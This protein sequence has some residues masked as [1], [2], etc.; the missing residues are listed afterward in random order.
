[1]NEM[2]SAGPS[3]PQAFYPAPAVNE[4]D[5]HYPSSAP[6]VIPSCPFPF[7]SDGV[8]QQFN[9]VAGLSSNTSNAAVGWEVIPEE[10][11]F[12]NSMQAIPLFPKTF[13]G[14]ESHA[15]QGN[16]ATYN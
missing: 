4:G 9:R 14:G 15:G 12:A 16:D 2:G 8:Y 13:L 11:G 6:E 10:I 1:M 7:P 5:L 3:D